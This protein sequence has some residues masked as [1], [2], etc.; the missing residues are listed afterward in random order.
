MLKLFAVTTSY[1]SGNAGGIFGPS[2]F[3]GAM[4][5]GTIGSVAHH[6]LPAY[7]ATPGA[8]ALV[9][10][11]ALFAGIVRAPMTSVLMIFE[12]TRDYSVIVP[13]MIA[14]LASL[15]ISSRFQKQPIYEA[16][17]HQDGIHL[18]NPKAQRDLE[19]R[20]VS[21]IMRSATETLLA[22]ISAREASELV[23]ASAFRAW[24]IMD[25]GSI[26]G[27]LNRSTIESAVADGKAD[28]SL[29]SL[30]DSLDFPH[31]HADHALHLALERMSSAHVDILP[32]VNRANVHKLE[33]VVTLKDVLDSY[34]IDPTG[35]A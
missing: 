30:L 11:G 5:G 15:F 35:S 9:G 1:A 22:E 19:Q 33:G 34:G 3:L 27:L 26:V 7:T 21:R 17:A 29:R 12:M 2:L 8:Y 18:P 23:R 14:N 20:R 28:Q 16:L 32:V 10:M 13:L 25:Q 4:L 6:F 24:P 31:V